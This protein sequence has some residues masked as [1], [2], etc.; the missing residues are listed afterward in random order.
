M[1]YNIE[2]FN[3]QVI[4]DQAPE[5]LVFLHGIMGQG[6]NWRSIAKHFSRKFQCLIYD[7]RGHGH[8]VHPE[9]DYGLK[10]YAEDLK[11]ILEGLA[12][13]DPIH[14]VGHS[15]GG[16]VAVQFASLHPE[17][18]KSLVIVD[19]GPTSDWASMQGILDKLNFVPTPFADRAQ[20]REFM[21]TQFLSKFPNP[22]V[23]E[24]FY[25]NLEQKEDG[26][27]DWIFEPAA[28]RQS[29]EASRVLDFWAEFH[30]LS[31]P[32]LLLRGEK[33]PDFKQEDFEKVVANNPHIRGEVVPGAGHWVHAEQPRKTIS[34]MENFFQMDVGL[35][36]C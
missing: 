3:Y 28:I 4:G 22:M 5:K 30:G 19:I 33:S 13:G 32:T 21:E 8:S 29:L 10:D 9:T 36:E 35:I 15:M 14:L 23:M 20:A 34:L 1:N 26:G 17:L 25:S 18:L 6:K 16:R 12:W 24:F 2:R 27:W 11:A 7:Q 31:M